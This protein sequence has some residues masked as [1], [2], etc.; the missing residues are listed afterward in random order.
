MARYLAIGHTRISGHTAAD[1]AGRIYTI[2]VAPQARAGVGYGGG[3]YRFALD[4][5][6][7]K[8]D[9]VAFEDSTQFIAAGVEL[10]AYGSAQLRL[11][12]RH[13]AVDSDRSV[14]SAGI[15]LSP[16]KVLHFD[17]A[18]TG[19]DNEVGGAAQLALTF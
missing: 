12:Y 18:I 4:A 8:N 11:G 7:T 14:A 15:G 16:F 17:V 19:S 9:P 5:D 2:K 3:W 6:L 13:D 10:D 1:S